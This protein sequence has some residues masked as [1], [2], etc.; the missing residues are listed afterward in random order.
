MTEEIL[1]YLTLLKPEIDK[2]MGPEQE[3]DYY[4]VNDGEPSQISCTC[5]SCIEEFKASGA[6]R[7]P[8]PLP[9]PGQEAG[10]TLWG[11]LAGYKELHGRDGVGYRVNHC[12]VNP[13]V[14]TFIFQENTPYLALLKTLAKQHGKEV[15]G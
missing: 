9:L 12:P 7:I 14:G 2:A 4:S 1:K 13:E 11:M 8:L 10:R 3:G 6:V 5:V 15:D